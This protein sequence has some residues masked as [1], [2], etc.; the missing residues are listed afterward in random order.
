MKIKGTDR[1]CSVS[2]GSVN[3]LGERSGMW[4]ESEN[5]G[6]VHSYSVL[7][8]KNASI[9]IF[10]FAADEATQAA[11]E[12]LLRDSITDRI[13]ATTWY[14]RSYIAARYWPRGVD[15]TDHVGGSPVVSSGVGCGNIH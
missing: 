3:I 13:A 6:I 5:N 11:Y 9:V 7:R 10:S 14:R 2:D 4:S 1:K 8:Q 12:A 15:G